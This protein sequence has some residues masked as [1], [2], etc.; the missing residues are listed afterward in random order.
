[1]TEFTNASL[2][3][4][5]VLLIFFPML[6]GLAGW[7]AGKK[8]KTAR[9][10]IVIVSAGMELAAALFLFVCALNGVYG[11]AFEIASVC[12]RGLNFKM[13]GFRVL[14]GTVAALMWFV[15]ALVSRE[16]FA[17][18]HNRNRYYLFFL[19][20]LG[21]TEGVFFSADFFTLFVFFEMM[22]FTSYVWVVQEETKDSIRAADTYLGVAVIGGLVLLMG[23]FLYE[24]GEKAFL[25]AAGLCML[26]GFGAKAGVF[27]LHIWLPKAHPVAPAPASALLSGILTK[28][29]VFGILLLTAGVFAENV[30]WASLIL[31]LGVAT[32]VVGAVLALFSVDLKRTLACSSVSQIG[33]ILVGIG[34]AGL[35]GAE[36]GFAV[37]GSTLHMINHSMIKLVLFLAAGVIFR[38]IRKLNLNEIRGFGRGKPLLQF[39][40]LMGALGIGGLPLWNGYLS[41]TLLHEGIVEYLELVR[42]GMTAGALSVKAL[43]G[44]EWAFLFS[45]GLTVAYMLKLYAAVF[46]EKNQDA[47]QQ[48]VFDALNGRYMNR[49]TAGALAVSAACLPL[50]GML[51][52]QLAGPLS[53]MGQSLFA[54]TDALKT[55]WFAAGNLKGAAISIA[56]GV[57]VYFLIVRG[58]MMKKQES[59]QRVYVDRWPVWLDLENLVYRPLLLKALPF[60]AGVLCRVLDSCVDFLVV[61]LRRTIYRDSRL[62]REQEEGTVFTNFA[63]FVAN[64]LEG[65]VWSGTD[66]TKVD[67]RH[68]FAMLHEEWNEDTKIIA[69]SLSFGLMLFCIGLLLTVLYLLIS[70]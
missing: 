50:A 8:N 62:P 49:L 10:A 18:H 48:K 5:T 13:D 54:G 20:T 27:P 19:L 30:R 9:N 29:G 43:K 41:K 7:F 31:T 28:T 16:Y 59:G 39:V 52:G 68:R 1:M 56:I 14:Y 25:P 12:G 36:N 47:K 11:S 60:L 23:L 55:D 22:S 66:R 32:M 42:S 21:A 64:G 17:Q 34:I 46:L 33:F 44:V 57:A 3:G 38:N 2:S 37:R 51:P 58:W 45:G 61:L 24:S 15:T 70:A 26:F 6:A 69:R 63:G 65:L 67:Y 53:D 35:P 4:F 40:F